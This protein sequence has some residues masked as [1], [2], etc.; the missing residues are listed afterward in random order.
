[1]K[2]D[3]GVTFKAILERL[4]QE[5]LKSNAALTYQKMLT[6]NKTKQKNPAEIKQLEVTFMKVVLS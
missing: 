3:C 1:M 4:R 2:A 5:N 6:R